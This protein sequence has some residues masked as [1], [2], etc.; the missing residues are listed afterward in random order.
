VGGAVAVASH[1]GGVAGAE[2]LEAARASF[3]TAAGAGVLV[4]AAIAALGALLAWRP[5]PAAAAVERGGDDLAPEA[6][7]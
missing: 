7:R 3:V 6:A 1:V 5:L 4:A 2:L